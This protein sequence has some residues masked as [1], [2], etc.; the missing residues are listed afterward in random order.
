M[1]H[2]VASHC[3]SQTADCATAECA[4][5]F[6]EGLLAQPSCTPGVLHSLDRLPVAEWNSQNSDYS[7]V[8]VPMLAVR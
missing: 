5:R 4:K 1:T 2:V 7:D 6:L 3:A 8:G